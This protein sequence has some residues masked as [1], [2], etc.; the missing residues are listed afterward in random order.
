MTHKVALPCLCITNA[1]IPSHLSCIRALVHSPYSPPIPVHTSS[2]LTHTSLSA[3]S[4]YSTPPTQTLS[5]KPSNQPSRAT[6]N[7][8]SSRQPPGIFPVKSA[9]VLPSW[10]LLH[11]PLHLGY[12]WTSHLP[13]LGDL[14]G[15]VSPTHT[16]I[17]EHL[18]HSEWPTKVI[19]HNH[20]LTL[21]ASAR[22]GT[23]GQ[24]GKPGPEWAFVKTTET[25]HTPF[26]DLSL[27]VR[28]RQGISWN[29]FFL[30]VK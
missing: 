24:D 15:C 3:G 16:P 21:V 19:A 6:R 29:L 2:H 8:T 12:S 9:H 28:Q 1:L 22:E 17:V 18:A 26:I 7:A 14:I 10:L 25:A 4:S 30:N 11:F 27:S 13:T 5:Q 20:S 23:H